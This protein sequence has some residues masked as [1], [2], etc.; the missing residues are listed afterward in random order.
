MTFWFGNSQPKQILRARITSLK[1]TCELPFFVFVKFCEHYISFLQNLPKIAKHP[2]KIRQILG[3]QKI[4]N[5]HLQI[6]KNLTI[7]FL[8]FPKRNSIQ[9]N[10]FYRQ[11]SRFIKRKARENLG[12]FVERLKLV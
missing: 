9:K 11:N 3:R 10:R 7:H 2:R 4:Q 12:K 1:K 8:G 6:G 5:L